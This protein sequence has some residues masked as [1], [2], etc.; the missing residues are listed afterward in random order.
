MRRIIRIPLFATTVAGVGVIA[1]RVKASRDRLG[2]KSELS[3]SS[4]NN[5]AA[6]FDL[7]IVGS[8][9]AG[10]T[11]ALRAKHLGLNSLVIEKSNKIG[12]TTMFSGG[13]L[14]IPNNGLHADVQDSPEEARR[15]L[16]RVVSNAGDAGPCSTPERRAAFIANGL[17]MVDFLRGQGFG[18]Q[19][20]V[21][22]PDYFPELPGGRAGGRS[23][24][25]AV[26]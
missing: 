22:Y 16:D 19:P 23:G 21:G 18:W 12:G 17:R 5:S 25:R 9:A 4:T 2:D 8:G 6:K 13:G 11:A 26:D 24:W 7:L 15:Y 14:W 20:S 1:G 10:L 3:L